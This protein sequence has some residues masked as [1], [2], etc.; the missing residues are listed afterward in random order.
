MAALL[1]LSSA[2]YTAG[3]FI[4]DNDLKVEVTWEVDT[5]LRRPAGLLF[6]PWERGAAPQ[7]TPTPMLH[8]SATETHLA[9]KGLRKRAHVMFHTAAGRLTTHR[10]LNTFASTSVMRKAI[11]IL[12]QHCT[13]QRFLWANTISITMIV[14]KLTKILLS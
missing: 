8:A 13:E 14:M 1:K 2:Q 3:L 6:G 4:V 7:R 10:N 5:T 12:M 9:E 11:P